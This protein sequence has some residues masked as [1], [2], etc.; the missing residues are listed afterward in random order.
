MNPNL[1][2]TVPTA[3]LTMLRRQCGSPTKPSDK[4]APTL[5]GRLVVQ[6]PGFA[7]LPV[8]VSLSELLNHNCT[9]SVCVCTCVIDEC[10]AKMLRIRALYG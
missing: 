8:K 4:W 3:D 6:S 5:I 9:P 1:C 2:K 10:K 7:G